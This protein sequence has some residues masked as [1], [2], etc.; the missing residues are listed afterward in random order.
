[1]TL[2][3]NSKDNSPPRPNIIDIRADK[4]EASLSQVLKAALRQDS[5]QRS[6]PDLLLWDAAGLKLFEEITFLDTYYLT[7]NEIRLL[8]RECDGIAKSIQPGSSKHPVLLVL[9][10]DILL[11]LLQKSAC[12]A[13]EWVRWRSTQD[14][15]TKMRV[16]DGTI[17]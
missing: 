3:G 13:R 12:R 10:P 15:A 14:N 9:T 7:N 8:E 4:D 16:T 17:S 1:M 11:T 6:L 5:P 2:H